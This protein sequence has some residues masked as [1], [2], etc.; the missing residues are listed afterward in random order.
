M[1]GHHHATLHALRPHWHRLAVV[2]TAHDLTFRTVLELIG[3]QVQTRLD[4]RVVEHRVLFA[5]GHVGET[6]QVCQHG[7]GAILSKDM[8]QSTR[9]WE[10]V[11]CEVTRDRGMCLAQLCAV[12][13]VASVAKRAKPLGTVG[14]TDD[15]ASTHDLAALVPPVAGGTD[16]IQPAK[17]R[18]SSSIW[19]KARW[20]AASRVPSTSKTI[21]VFPAQSTR[22]PISPVGVSFESGRLSRSS[23]KSVRRASTGASV[24]AAKKRERVERA[25][26]RSRSRPGHEGDRKGLEPLVESFQGAFPTDGIP[27]EDREK[28]DELGSWVGITAHQPPKNRT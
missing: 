9:L 15:G 3:R 6:S 2:E 18:G 28:I 25:G 23:R 17:G 1:G 13:T 21:H 24:S 11:R 27:E 20:R 26:S 19:G 5:A 22:P 16:I 14:L 8:Q 12:A 10:L 4:E 7:P